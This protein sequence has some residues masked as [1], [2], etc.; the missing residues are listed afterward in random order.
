MARDM[1]IPKEAAPEEGL[2]A[3]QAAIKEHF[4]RLARG[5]NAWIARNRFFYDSDRAYMRF[6]IP[7]SR[8]VLEVGCGTGQLL[9][10]LKPSYGVGIDLSAEMIRVARA[11]YPELTFHVA[12]AEDA[13]SLSC[14]QGRFDF[15][16]LSDLVGYLDDCEAAFSALR[17]FCHPRTRVIVAYYSRLWEPV[18]ALGERIGQKM[19]SLAQ[20]WLSTTDTTNLLTLAG[21]EVIRREW[22]QL[23]PKRLFGIG[24][25]VNRFIA[26][27]PGIRRLSL[28]NYVIARPL[29]ARESAL[30]P[31]CT[32]VVPCRNERGNIESAVR[33]VP[34]F[35]SHLEILFVEGHSRDGTYE[36]CA[37]VRDAYPRRDIRLLRQPGKGKGD[38]VRAGFSAARG[39]IVMILDADLTVPPEAMPKFYNVLVRGQGELVNGTRMIYPMSG[40]AMR[41]LNAIG[42][43]AF[44][45]IFSYLLNQRFTDT[46]C[47]TK[48]L[49]RRDYEEIAANRS[50]F[51]DFDPFGDFDLIFGAAKLNLK[52]IELPVR[53][54]ERSYGETQISRFTHGW[55]LLRMV[56]FAWRMLKAI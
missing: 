45:F 13:A 16:V 8:S 9:A 43:R 38:A 19:P 44:A 27:W 7:Q 50:Y 5:R 33:R 39:E 10:A 46:L 14:I 36:E 37:R 34:E 35:S 51:G 1:T 21:F 32:V 24:G 53:Y 31:S 25:L 15:I 47:G 55:L 48:A 40:D 12:N 54:S 49:W 6:L 23:L 17:R 2:S 52:I 42:N 11:E 18:L 29:L 20:N 22:R 28:R 4:N 30:A 56:I 3:R 41:N 26:P